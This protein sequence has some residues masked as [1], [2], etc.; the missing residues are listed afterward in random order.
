MGD[1]ETLVALARELVKKS[2]EHMKLSGEL[3]EIR[4]RMK[5]ALSNGSDLRQALRQPG[6]EG[7]ARGSRGRR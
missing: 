1:E 4:Q 5:A 6:R 2:A 3:H 7:R